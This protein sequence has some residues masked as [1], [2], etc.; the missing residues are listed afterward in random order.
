LEGNDQPTTERRG[1]HTGPVELG[2][3]AAR[4][5]KVFR[6]PFAGHGVRKAPAEITR[7]WKA[8]DRV[9]LREEASAV[10]VGSKIL[11][12]PS[13]RRSD[14]TTKGVGT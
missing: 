13:R 11:W 4:L 5:W 14:T 10:L 2:G 9:D 7:R 12:I 8:S 1:S 6:V 3:V